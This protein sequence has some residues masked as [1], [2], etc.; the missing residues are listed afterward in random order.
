MADEVKPK[1][2]WHKGWWYKLPILV[3][4]VILVLYG[5]VGVGGG[6][7][8]L[9]TCEGLGPQIVKL[10][11]EKATPFNPAILKLYEITAVPNIGDRF[12]NCTARAKMA[13]GAERQIAFYATRDADGDEFIRYESK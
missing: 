2:K 13:R 1:K 11:K 10:S 3:V 6:G 5:V 7:G 12:L 4:G 8:S 9:T